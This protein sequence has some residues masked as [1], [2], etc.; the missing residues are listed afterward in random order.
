M[1][2]KK[3]FILPVLL[4]LSYLGSQAQFTMDGQLR[5]RFEYRDGYKIQADST[6]NPAFVTAQRSRLNLNYKKDK[7]KVKFSIQD[8]RVWGET[9]NKNDSPGIGVHEAWSEILFTENYS[10]KLGRQELKYDDKRILSWNNWN[11]IG[12]SHDLALL[13]YDKSK[14]QVHFGLAYNNDV[15]KNFESNYPVDFY[16]AMQFLW[17]SKEFS[18]GLNFSLIELADGH[19]KHGS[20]NFVYTRVTYGGNIGFKNDSSKVNLYGTIYLQGGKDKTGKDINSNFFSV[21]AS[22]KLSEKIKPSA[23]IDYFSGNDAMDTNNTYNNA[24]SNL[25]GTGHGYYGSMDYFTV[26]D[27]HTL[28][29]GLIDIY[30]KIDYKFSDKTSASATYHT[31]SLSNNVL[32]PDYTGTGLKAIDKNLGS[33]VDL[34][35]NYK[36]SDEIDLK[37]GYSVMFAK[38]SMN[39]IKGGDHNELANWAFVMLTFKPAFIKN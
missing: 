30:G 38:E 9:K 1:N 20:S 6:T 4:M 5:P 11:N 7:L 36:Y 2:R 39:V 34:M 33:E 22:Y 16:K 12:S 14:L 23:G 37:F 10:L 28:G 24:F 35:F 27:K 19:Q 13:K 17:F 32:D 31:F 18:N 25:Y 26:V 3:K 21:K 29:G 8:V 15:L